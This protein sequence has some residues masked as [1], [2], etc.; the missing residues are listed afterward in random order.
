LDTMV[1]RIGDIEQMLR[2]PGQPSRA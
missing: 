2:P 1:A